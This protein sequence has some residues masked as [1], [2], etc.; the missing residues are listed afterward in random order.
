MLRNTYVE[1][2]TAQLTENVRHIRSH[3]PEYQTYFGVVKGNVYGHG[4]NAIQALIAGG[5]NYL[6]ISSLEEALAIRADYAEIPILCLEPVDLA[7]LSVVLENAV[8]ITVESLEQAAELAEKPL[9]SPLNVHI[10]LDTGMSRLG[11]T[12]RSDF[13][14]AL[15]LLRK[16]PAITVEGLY[17]HL[18]TSGVYDV[19]YDRQI[20][21]F[22]ALT[23]GIDLSDIPLVHIGRSITLAHHPKIE[24]VNAI[25]LG[26]CLYGFNNS[27]PEPTGLRKWKRKWDLKRLS[28]SESVLSNT[29]PVKTAFALYTEVI[30]LRTVEAGS[31]IGYG[32]RFV[33]PE[34]MRIATLPIG[35]YDGMDKRMKEVVIGG[36]HYEIVGELCMDMTMVK[37]D[38][39]VHLHDRVEIFGNQISVRTTAARTGFNAYRLLTSI[40]SR[41]PRIEKRAENDS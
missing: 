38:D 8:T 6:A 20:A 11:F 22:R 32:A 33:A 36:R 17:T 24:G 19:Y 39:H 26:I 10:K 15:S 16:N 18:A 9:S 7:Y 2:D 1:I 21:A 40:D 29:L 41:L 37:V 28:I 3:Y 13:E 25:R 5:I 27:L 31:F 12:D 4:L 14:K 23:Q 34:K 35:Y 30:S